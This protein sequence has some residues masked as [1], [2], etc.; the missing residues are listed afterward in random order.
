MKHK[1]TKLTLLILTLSVATCGVNPVTKKRELQLVSEEKEIAIGTQNYSPT[2]Q[3]QGGDYVLDPELTAYVQSVGD[4]L[5]AVSDRK[6]PYE[7]AVINDSV[8]NAWAM[9][10]GKIAFNRGLLYE[11]HS[12][13]ELAAVMG[14]EMVHAAAR[15]GAQGMER[16]ILLQGAMVAVGIG[17]QN[18]D[19]ANLIVG[20]A[21]VGAQLVNSKYG[22]DAES[23]SDLYG[24]QYMKKAGYDPT[25]AVTL[26]ET[27][28]RLS[29]GRKS[30]FIEGLFASH[31]P[32]PE[33][34]AANKA[35]LAQLG[36]GGDWGKEIYAQK[37]AK[38]RATQGAYKA[39]DEA[40]KALND[41]N[42]DKA[43]TLVNQAIAI[44]PKEARFQELLGDIALTQKKPQEALA[45]YDKAIK[46]QPD[47]F[48]PHIQ[49]GIALFN[50]GKKAE[51]EPFLK[52]ANQLLPTAPG[53]ALL[54]Q[55]A[56]DRGDINGALQHYQVAASSNSDIGK[57][58]IARAVKIDLPRNPAKYIQSAA[59]ADNSGNLYAVVQNS[60]PIAINRV[61]VRVVKY[62]ANTGR[63]VGQSG[64]LTING[65]APGKRNQVAVG[66]RVNNAKEVGLYKVVVESAELAQ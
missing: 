7:Y 35:T 18:T 42:I 31:P 33:R 51:A 32:S 28:V 37:T 50:M 14:H 1:L 56:E 52:R 46:M 59:Q 25:A 8:P 40:V 11:L 53:H 58:A 20:G 2:R 63:A 61:V 64:L 27:F 10:G 26:Q 43:K 47:Y 22:R 19:Y 24:M 4:K 66:V 41:K 44:E 3:S 48:K 54:G 9:P 12:E 29:E 36:A 21:Q 16:G 45:F 30:N 62:D 65:V 13:A 38:L 60:T 15:H 17:A 6:L 34:V 39:Y 23:E 49:S 5:A 55:L 57:D